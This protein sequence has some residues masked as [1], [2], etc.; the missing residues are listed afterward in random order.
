MFQHVWRIE[1]KSYAESTRAATHASRFEPVSGSKEFHAR[2]SLNVNIITSNQPTSCSSSNRP[3]GSEHVRERN[4][5]FKRTH[6]RSLL[7]EKSC[8]RKI[9]F[10]LNI[11]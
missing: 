5:I 8:N 4:F 7:H 11:S 6:A 1:L 10:K 2:V 3:I 9:V